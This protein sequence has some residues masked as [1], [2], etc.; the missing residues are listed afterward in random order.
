MTIESIA[1]TPS[2]TL[3]FSSLNGGKPNAYDSLAA[4]WCARRCDEVDRI[5]AS[6]Q[7][8]SITTSPTLTT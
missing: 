6:A 2:W 7:I 5:T 3:V 1:P 8:P 4:H